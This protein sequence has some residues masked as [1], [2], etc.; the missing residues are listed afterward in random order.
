MFN[1]T[2]MYQIKYMYMLGEIIAKQIQ[3]ILMYR[4][5]NANQS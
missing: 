2:D 3:Y 1:E 5:M 4:E